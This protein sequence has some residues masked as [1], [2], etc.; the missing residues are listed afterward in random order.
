MKRW[1]EQYGT[2]ITEDSEGRI[3]PDWLEY[4]KKP[5]RNQKVFLATSLT[6]KAAILKCPEIFPFLLGGIYASGAHVAFDG[7]PEI[8]HTVCSVDSPWLTLLSKH[9]KEWGYHLL[10][11][12]HD[13][14]PYKIVL[15]KPHRKEWTDGDIKLSLVC[16]RWI[17]CVILLS[18]TVFRLRRR[19]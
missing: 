15:A 8:F 18:N 16:C 2:L 11:H 12:R 3:P 10:I 4:L 14:R 6:R 1:E 5:E 9:E 17:K 19:R 7:G 13:G